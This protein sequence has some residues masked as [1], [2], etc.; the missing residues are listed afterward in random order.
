M[1]L[2]SHL[3]V[4]GGLH[5]ALVAAHGYG[6]DCVAVFVRNQVQWARSALT[7]AAVRTFRQTRRRLGIG[8]V[9]AH[10]SYLV[11]LAGRYAVRRKSIAATRHDLGRCDRLGIEYLVVH[12]GSRESTA[13]GTRLIAEAL[14]S[15][16]SADRPRGCR[17]ARPK[18]LLETTA[19]QG[20][21]IGHTFEQLA[22]ILAAVRPRGRF[23]VCL[24]TCH[25]FA[26]GYDIRTAREYEKTMARLDRT[27]G[28]E[29]VLAVH[30]NDSVGDLGSRID[31][32]A[33]IGRGKI[34]RKG[35]ANLVG[36]PRF[37][38]VPMILE[39]PKGTDESGRD[40]DEINARRV[41]RLAR[42]ACQTRRDGLP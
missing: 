5:K 2:G 32:H 7:D 29:N 37:A 8:P 13:E 30:L 6:F 11:N 3:S 31:R 23:G 4:A 24:D 19:G 20:N 18:I 26:A 21:C 25:L 36:D 34:R 41:R 33:H 16:V 14:A 39:T 17:G 28:L 1:L 38:G 35:F 9:I 40:F 15:I 12:P 27:I 10:G 42:R 22:E